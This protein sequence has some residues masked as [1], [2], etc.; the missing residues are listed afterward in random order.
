MDQL[1][2]KPLTRKVHIL[3]NHMKDASSPATPW[4]GMALR[5]HTQGERKR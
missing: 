1:S 3:L 5:I 4:Q 2:S